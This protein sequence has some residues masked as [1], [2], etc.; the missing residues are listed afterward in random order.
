MACWCL[1]LV[2]YL[3]RA[4]RQTDRQ[5]GNKQRYR[6]RYLNPE[7]LLASVV[8]YFYIS[9]DTALPNDIPSETST[10]VSLPSINVVATPVNKEASQALE[11]MVGLIN[12]PC[13]ASKH[14]CHHNQQETG[15][16]LLADS[17]IFVSSK[18]PCL[19]HLC[20]CYLFSPPKLHYP[21]FILLHRLPVTAL[22]ALTLDKPRQSVP[23]SV[24]P[25]DMQDMLLC[26]S[27]GNSSSNILRGGFHLIIWDNIFALNR[28]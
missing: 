20:H 10:T 28:L 7:K 24:P 9:H 25:G 11:E 5:T 22:M 8:Y 3:N 14:W 4:D 17:S 18:F 12:N 1:P 19:Q 26:S 16:F 13:T 27:S 15:N 2:S 23:C 21:F 6:G